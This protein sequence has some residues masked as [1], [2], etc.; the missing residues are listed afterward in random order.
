MPYHLV[1]DRLLLFHE[2]RAGLALV[3]TIASC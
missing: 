1:S 2:K 3:V